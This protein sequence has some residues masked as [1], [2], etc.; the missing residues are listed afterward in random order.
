M[1]CVSCDRQKKKLL[2]RFPQL[3][4]HAND[5]YHPICT[6]VIHTYIH[7]Y[8][9]AHMH[10]C[11][12]PCGHSHTW[13]HEHTHTHTHT[14]THAYTYTQRYT[15]TYKHTHTYA[16]T[17]TQRYIHTYTHIQTHTHTHTQRC[18]SLLWTTNLPVKAEG[19]CSAQHGH[20]VICPQSSPL[21]SCLPNEISLLIFVPRS[22]TS[23]SMHN[24][25]WDYHARGRSIIYNNLPSWGGVWLEREKLR[26]KWCKYITFS[27]NKNY[28]F[29]NINIKMS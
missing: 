12:W 5:E 28:C 16:Y 4:H 13:T 22:L 25:S 18:D 27:K 9:Q 26:G 7:T 19:V 24:R 2:T 1:W 14:H 20:T 21:C 23:M 8:I 11:T 17:Y 3:K 10:A 29:K 15:H 6:Y